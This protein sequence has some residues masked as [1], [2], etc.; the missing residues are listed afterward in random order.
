MAKRNR[1]NGKDIALIIA[2]Y[3][4]S[5]FKQITSHGKPAKS[6]VA[7]VLRTDIGQVLAERKKAALPQPKT[8]F[9]A[10]RAGALVVVIGIMVLF[11]VIY[12]GI[13][14]LASQPTPTPAPGEAVAPDVQSAVTQEM[15]LTAQAVAALPT[16]TFT[17]IPTATPEPVWVSANRYAPN[18]EEI[19]V[20]VGGLICRNETA[21]VI[22]GSNLVVTFAGRTELISSADAKFTTEPKWALL[23]AH[24]NWGVTYLD[25]SRN[26]GQS[27]QFPDV[28]GWV[29]DNKDCRVRT[30]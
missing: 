17:A 14:V 11:G 30:P 9:F 24:S 20:P 23:V 4:L 10:S 18:V 29:I 1:A 22:E 28:T 21:F 12:G 27:S 15:G 5:F 13:A 3:A 25:R 8:P 16:P 19:P 26:S 6:A 2:G 7:P